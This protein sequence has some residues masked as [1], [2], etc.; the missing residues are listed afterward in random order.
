MRDKEDQAAADH[1]CGQAQKKHVAIQ[2]IEEFGRLVVGGHY[3][4]ADRRLRSIRELQRS[5]Q[6]TFRPNLDIMRLRLGRPADDR[7]DVIDRELVLTKRRRDQ[8]VSAGDCH[9]A[10]RDLAH[11]C[12]QPMVDLV[13]DHQ[14]SEHGSIGAGSAVY[15]LNKSLVKMMLAKPPVT[16]HVAIFER[17]LEILLGSFAAEA[18]SLGMNCKNFAGPVDQNE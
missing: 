16:G 7:S 3:G 18:R 2:F 4:E 1:N 13:S 15:R 10:A 14:K 5:G 12:R 11:L 8:L 6:V 17:L 9:V